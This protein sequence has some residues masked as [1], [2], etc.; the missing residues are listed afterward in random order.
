MKGIDTNVLVRYLVQDDP[1]QSRL[2]T[3]FIET[4]CSIK[5]PAFVNAIVLCELVWVLETAYG[6]ARSDISRVLEKILQARQLQV[7]QVDIMWKA[8]NSY[9]EEGAD[10]ADNYIGYLNIQKGCDNTVTFDK[11]AAKLKNFSQLGL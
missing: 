3:E 11:K 8:L 5:K 2:A 1:K 9:R 4:E 10:F 7:E 6:Y